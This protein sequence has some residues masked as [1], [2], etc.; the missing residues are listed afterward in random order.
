M[1]SAKEVY[2]AIAVYLLQLSVQIQGIDPCL[3]GKHRSVPAASCREIL[4]IQPECYGETGIY[5]LERDG[6]NYEVYCDMLHQGGGWLR[7][8]S[9][10]Q[11]QINTTCP[12][13][14]V[15]QWMS[16]STK[17]YC[18]K[19]TEDLQWNTDGYVEYSEV[20]GYVVIRVKGG[21][22]PDGFGDD[23]VSTPI[24]TEYMDGVAIEV[25]RPH[26]RHIF[27]Y[28]VAITTKWKRCP[29]PTRAKDTIKPL[30]MRPFAE[31][32]FACQDVDKF[33]A[34][35]ADGYYTDYVHSPA[36][37]DCVLCPLGMPWFQV[38]FGETLKEALQI[39]FMDGSDTA[40][41]TAITDMEVYVR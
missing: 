7:V 39:R 11:D 24:E 31:S 41:G 21:E 17:L 37:T 8:F 23:V 16:N 13:G 38:S 32:S 20:R 18:L 19:G 9:H 14:W 22:A 25:F 36:Y 6:N 12:Q 26:L 28:V 40:S 3:Y 29:L 34:T 2:F 35:D 4:D 1:N 27:S 33:G 10:H 30:F 15:N 5:W